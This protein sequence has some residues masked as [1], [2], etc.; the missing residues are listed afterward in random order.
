MFV[1]LKYLALYGFYIAG[2][3]FVILALMGRI[4]LPFYLMV[5]LFPL[6]N[7]VEKLHQLPMGKDFID[8]LII[9][10][11]IGWIFSAIGQKNKF[12]EKSLLNAII[13]IMVL[14]TIFSY[15]NGFEYLRYESTF[16]IA[17]SRLE[18]LKN[19]IILPFLFFFT[20]NNVKNKKM[21]IHLLIVM[22]LTMA[23]MNFYLTRQMMWYSS[24]ES[25][26]KL[27][28]TFV[29]FGANEIAAFYNMYTTVLIG[30][31]FYLKNNRLKLILGGLI[32]VN[33]F[34]ILFLFSRGAYIALAIGLLFIFLFRARILIVP[35][36][37]VLLC[38]QVALPEKVQN[39]I[40][41]T[42]NEYGQLDESN[43]GRLEI[44]K[45]SL[46]LFNKNPVFG[47]GFGVFQYLGFN[48]KDTHNI[49]LKILAEQGIVGLFI[50][51]LLLMIL[52]FQ[53][54]KLFNNSHD[55]LGK[56]LG[57]GMSACIVVLL[58]NNMFGDRWSYLE[59]S[60]YLWIFA[61]LIA[62][63]NAGVI[64]DTLKENKPVRIKK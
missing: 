19:F 22:G 8:I 26:T 14:Y 63:Y 36:L 18:N 40:K 20:F 42:T 15:F 48:L 56:G 59:L 44:W 23:L 52:F 62:R 13:I 41:M 4:K 5:A 47:I 58:I 21:I 43:L 61:G 10:L 31:F 46:E 64:D 9:S 51:L 27:T 7:V 38:W 53:S 60:A 28:A 12:M 37:L 34:C 39:R 45:Q 17:T 6:R 55:E 25:R 16:G 33:L 57:L 11:F 35:L 2:G 32:A 24:I 54:F 49:Y 29:F 3:V 1:L 50:L 30:I